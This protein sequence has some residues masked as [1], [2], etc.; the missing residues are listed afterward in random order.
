MCSSIELHLKAK[1]FTLPLKSTRKCIFYVKM[2]RRELLPK[3]KPYFYIYAHICKANTSVVW[4]NTNDHK[5]KEHYGW[6]KYFCWN[7]FIF[8]VVVTF[9]K[10]SSSKLLFDVV[11]FDVERYIFD[12]KQLGLCIS[13]LFSPPPPARCNAVNASSIN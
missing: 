8:L 3:G 5:I 9:F 4:R 13:L 10:V 7:Y 6:R 11:V 1:I 2:H 12:R